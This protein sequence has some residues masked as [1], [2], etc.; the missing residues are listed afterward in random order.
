[1][2]VSTSDTVDFDLA[3]W[4]TGQAAVDAATEDGEESPPPN[5]YYVRNTN[6][7]MRTLSVSP[8]ADVT[9]YPTGDPNA[10]AH[11]TLTEWRAMV[12][13]RG[14]YF[15]VWLDVTGGEVTTITEQWVP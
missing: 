7:Q 4:F 6:E 3:C 13:E 14:P 5:D 11:G 2:T 9:F 1:V 12:E 15:G 8:D 10:E